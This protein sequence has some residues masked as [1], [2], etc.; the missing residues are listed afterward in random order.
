MRKTFLLILI[1]IFSV[2]AYGQDTTQTARRV[3]VGVSNASSTGTTVNRLA[4]LTGAPS[5]ALIVATTDTDGAIGV[6]V[7]GAGT[8]G[9][10]T[11]QTNGQVGSSTSGGC[12]FDG[13]TTAGDYVQIS[14]ST[15]G[16]CHDTG[17]ST[18]PTSGQVIGRVLSTN[19]SAGTYSIL[20]TPGVKGA[21]A[22]DVVG[23]ASS[24]DNAV[25]RF[26]STTG[27]LL[28]NSLAT[29]DDSGSVNIPTGQTYKINNVALA[30]GDVGLGNVDNTSDANKPVSTAQQTAL[31]LK[32]NLTANAFSAAQTISSNS[33]T[34]LTVGANGS[35]NSALQVDASTASSAT[36]VKVTSAAAGSGVTLAAISSGSDEDVII[37]AK[38]A[39]N[40]KLNPASNNLVLTQA[41]ITGGNFEG[42]NTF[43]TAYARTITGRTFALYGSA[44]SPGYGLVLGSNAGVRWTSV[45]GGSGS[46][47]AATANVATGLLPST[48]GVV[49]LFGASTST[50]GGLSSVA[51]SPTQIAANTNDYSPGIGLFQRWSSD[52]SRNVTGMVAGAVGE[53]RYIWN[54]GAQ[55][56]VLI[57][58]SASSAAANRFTT[59][60]GADLTL[61][62]NKCALAMYDLTSTTWRVTLLP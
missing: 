2:F 17:A 19:G 20:L 11:I 59:S 48:A 40:V 38:G 39:G 15:A 23:P 34:A 29:V 27:K 51:N 13:A 35:T 30:K 22:A 56:I 62:A 12:A 14:S 58:A 46:D 24:T 26:D 32:A 49:Q 7:S 31:N 50:S 8:S 5:T 57:N 42:Y 4:K 36:G 1:I 18:Y 25:A 54:V 55:N 44:A 10:A 21:G 16:K 43:A 53:M 60:T 61:G 41:T 47:A 28:Q 37:A 52:A 9:V 6:V 45:A 33:A 3:V